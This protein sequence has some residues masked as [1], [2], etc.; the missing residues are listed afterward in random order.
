M[1][2]NGVT[3][4]LRLFMLSHRRKHTSP[5]NTN[6]KRNKDKQGKK[7]ICNRKSVVP[8]GLMRHI[9]SNNQYGMTPMCPLA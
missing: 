4:S 2:Q 7:Y 5:R 1:Q 9:W 8:Y 6:S 3:K